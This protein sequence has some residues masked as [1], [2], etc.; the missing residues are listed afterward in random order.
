VINDIDGPEDSEE[1]QLADDILRRTL[2]KSNYSKLKRKPVAKSYES[3]ERALLAK[4]SVSA[5][6]HDIHRE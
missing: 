2:T 6:L 5:V 4:I 3:K 1:E